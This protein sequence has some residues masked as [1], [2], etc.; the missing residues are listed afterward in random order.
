MSPPIFFDKIFTYLIGLGQ[1]ATDGNS[2]SGASR[3]HRVKPH[4]L[5]EM[6]VRKILV[7]ISQV[8]MNDVLDENFHDP[9]SI[10]SLSNS[11]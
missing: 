8:I 11:I 5:S 10:G 4:R 9:V 3:P 1:V 7:K 2:A 6:S